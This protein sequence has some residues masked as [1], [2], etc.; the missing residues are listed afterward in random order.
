MSAHTPGEWYADGL[1]ILANYTDDEGNHHHCHVADVTNRNE[2]NRAAS[3]EELANASLIAAAPETA[4]ER[5]RLVAT[6]ATM[7]TGLQ[8]Q[9]DELE[10]LKADKERLLEALEGC[11]AVGLYEGR[12]GGDAYYSVGAPTRQEKRAEKAEQ[13]ARQAIAEAKKP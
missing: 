2:T 13:K 1:S 11:L 8:D 5:D 7:T 10:R 3:P 12:S 9:Q 6:I 4:A